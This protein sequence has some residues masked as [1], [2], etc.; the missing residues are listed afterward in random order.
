MWTWRIYN[1]EETRDWASIATGSAET[2][3]GA[4][5]QARR[6]IS[7]DIKGKVIAGRKTIVL[8][9]RDLGIGG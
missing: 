1:A 6:A 5:R 9:E 4:K 8:S 3:W 2:L 7:S